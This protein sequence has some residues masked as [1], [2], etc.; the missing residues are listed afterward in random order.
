MPVRLWRSSVP[1]R[2]GIVRR[3][4]TL[5]YMTSLSAR[6]TDTAGRRAAPQV[7]RMQGRLQV[8]KRRGSI[9]VRVGVKSARALHACVPVLHVAG[10]APV[11][12]SLRLPC[13]G[14]L[15]HQPTACLLR[16]RD[17]FLSHAV[18]ENQPDYQRGA[19]VQVCTGQSRQP[20]PPP[21]AEEPAAHYHGIGGGG[22]E[23]RE[24]RRRL[25]WPGGG[26]VVAGRWPDG[27]VRL[28]CEGVGVRV[29]GWD[30]GWLIF[31]SVRRLVCR[32]VGR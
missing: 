2:A 14:S 32:S 3:E 24:G 22:G 23:G 15:A 10:T 30:L 29:V 18:I 4:A 8:R 21:Q 1:F 13:R 26:R 5:K 31:Q 27:A 28:G 17:A 16:A 12:P 11:G 20:H 7:Q 19:W 25:L 6:E 9:S